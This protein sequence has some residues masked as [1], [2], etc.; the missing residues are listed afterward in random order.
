MT[1][2]LIVRFASTGRRVK[3]SVTELAELRELLSVPLPATQPKPPVQPD[4][5]R[6]F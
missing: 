2:E 5:S 6:V 3:L 1:T 4:W